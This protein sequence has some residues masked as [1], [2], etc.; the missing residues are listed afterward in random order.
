VQRQA[1]VPAGDHRDEPLDG[2]LA[3]RQRTGRAGS[4]SVPSADGRRY[5]EHSIQ[6]R[7]GASGTSRCV[8]T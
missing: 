6:V 7:F 8:I 5:H 1:D 3:R 2:V 4:G